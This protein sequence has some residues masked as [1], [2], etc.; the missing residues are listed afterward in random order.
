[1]PSMPETAATGPRSFARLLG[2]TYVHADE[3]EAVVEVMPLPEHCN[4]RGTVHGGFLASL[5]DTTTGL[6]V[7]KVLPEGTAAPHFQLTVQ[8][9]NAAVPGITLTCVGRTTKSGRR[10]ASTDAEVCQD[11]KVIARAMA[12]HVIL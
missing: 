8:Y 2:F 3:H 1:M 4:E 6:A 11:G 10:A 5:L 7:H 9:L 12:S